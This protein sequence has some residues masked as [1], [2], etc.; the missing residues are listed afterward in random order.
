MALLHAY[1]KENCKLHGSS[2]SINMTKN[3]R[4]SFLINTAVAASGLSLAPSLSY[5]GIKPGTGDKIKLG[6]IGTGDRGTGL[7][8]LLRQVPDMELVAC[9]DIIPSRLENAMQYASS[10]AKA[11]KDYRSVL[12]DKNVD[13][14]IIA[15]PFS[16]HADMAVDALGAGKHI[17]CEKTL[18]YGFEATQRLVKAARGSKKIFQTGHQYHSSRLYHKAFQLIHSGY[19]GEISAFECQWNRN[20][21]WRREVPA[22]NLERMINWRMYREYSGGLVAELC[23]HQIDF[24]NWVL[25]EH[26]EKITGFG[27]IDY[28]KDGR[29][30]YDNIHL[31]MEYPSGVNAKYTCLTTNS[32]DDYKIEVLGKK[33]S[34]VITYNQAWIYSEPKERQG[35]LAIVDGVSGATKKAWE[36]GKGAPLD[37]QHKDP[38]L[39]ALLD[40]KESILK[41]KKPLSNVETGAKVAI[42]VQL[43]LNAMDHNRVEYWKKEY[44]F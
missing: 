10:G 11:Y 38:S 15:T 25:D 32:K 2:A 20:G 19:L 41:E 7:A 34:L 26:P 9:C 35:E 1:R 24:A 5:S 33:G 12:D 23:S 22:S 14:V 36:E 8:H 43:A 40:F 4:R 18:A 3:S 13:A 30:T 6:V 28:W 37:V 42:A 21:N 39:Q 31:V 44:N 16:M 17:Y 27:G 29:E